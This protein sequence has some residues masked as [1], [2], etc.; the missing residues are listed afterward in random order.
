MLIGID[1][2]K[3]RLWFAIFSGW[4]RA[5]LVFSIGEVYKDEFEER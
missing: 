4:S 5:L 2:F 1:L 3:I